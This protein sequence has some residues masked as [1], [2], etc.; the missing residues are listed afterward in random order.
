MPGRQHRRSYA[1]RV[2]RFGGTVQQYRENVEVVKNK[3]IVCEVS[4]FVDK[5]VYPYG[6]SKALELLGQFKCDL[7][8]EN[9]KLQVL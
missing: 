5:N 8:A 6:Q 9:R 7:E 4:K 3:K 1:E 2:S